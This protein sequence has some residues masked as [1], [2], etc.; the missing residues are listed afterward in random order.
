MPSR[1]S[2]SRPPCK[3]T[4]GSI[5][6][7][8]IAAL[9]RFPRAPTFPSKPET[10]APSTCWSPSSS[11]RHGGG[12]T[13]CFPVTPSRWID[14]KPPSIRLGLLANTNRSRRARCAHLT[15]KA[16]A[17]QP[18]V[19]LHPGAGTAGFG[20]SVKSG[21]AA[22]M[23]ERVE[24][25]PSGVGGGGFVVSLSFIASCCAAGQCTGPCAHETCTLRHPAACSV[26][27]TVHIAQARPALPRSWANFQAP[28]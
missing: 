10:A 11:A 19:L 2:W 15:F 20:V 3:S 27:A 16:K 21:A 13:F 26:G 28:S 25:A 14:P 17:A 22:A 9:R 7:R 6:A 4:R 18:R 12:I 8:T 23:V 24:A 5:T 1:A